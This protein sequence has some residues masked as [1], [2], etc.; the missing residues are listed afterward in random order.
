[1]LLL[2]LSKIPFGNVRTISG[3]RLSAIPSFSSAF[4][5][6]FPDATLLKTRVSAPSKASLSFCGVE[7]S[8]TGLLLRLPRPTPTR[9]IIGRTRVHGELIENK[10]LMA[11]DPDHGGK[12]NADTNS[13]RKKAWALGRWDIVAA[14]AQS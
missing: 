14:F 12:L 11:T 4:A 3:L 9:P 2:T 13:M 8:Y 6:V 5:N 1:M 10:A 7:M